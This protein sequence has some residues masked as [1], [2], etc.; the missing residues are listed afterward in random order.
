MSP[1]IPVLPPARHAVLD[2]IRRGART[3]NALAVSLRISDNA[4]RVHLVS[5]ERDGLIVRSGLVRSGAAGQPAAEYEL[6]SV[7]ELTLSSAYPA[8]MVALAGA[9]GE[10]LDARA[11]RALFLEAGKRLAAT[12]ADGDHGTLGARAD[13]CA[14]LIESL[15][16][17]A[18]ITTGRGHVMLDGVG[19]PLAAAVRDEPATCALV[20]GLL[21]RHTGVNAEQLCN[22]GDRPSCRFRLTA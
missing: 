6:T 2:L 5:L 9:I 13:A 11:R 8:A 18:T 21:E 19:C 20:E 1:A 22:H 17:S 10:K 4:V 3:V 12:M 14:K 7:G 15:G 16:G